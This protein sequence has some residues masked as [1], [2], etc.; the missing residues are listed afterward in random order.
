MLATSGLS[1]LWLLGISQMYAATGVCILLAL[2]PAHLNN[3]SGQISNR[4]GQQ[5]L[6]SHPKWGLERFQG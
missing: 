5:P 2:I 6:V 4:L 1:T 3:R